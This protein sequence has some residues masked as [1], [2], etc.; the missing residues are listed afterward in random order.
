MKKSLGKSSIAGSVQFGPIGNSNRKRK[1][2]YDDF[3]GQY[4]KRDDDE[5]F[6][7][8]FFNESGVVIASYN[9]PFLQ[10]LRS[11]NG[12]GADKCG[13]SFVT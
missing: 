1:L 10:K 12:R 4:N 5:N 3:K 11:C 6:V 9:F 2:I 7:E 13:K 8:M